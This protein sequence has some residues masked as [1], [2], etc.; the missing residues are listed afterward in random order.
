MVSAL[1]AMVRQSHWRVPFAA[2]LDVLRAAYE[3]IPE[4]ERHLGVID[5]AKTIEELKRGLE[6]ASATLDPD[7]REVARRNQ[8]RLEQ[9]LTAKPECDW[10]PNPFERG[11]GERL[12]LREG[13]MTVEYSLSETRGPDRSAAETPR[14]EPEDE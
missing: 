6:R 5:S 7:P 2:V 1:R 8:R 9:A 14:S 11:S 4:T 12:T 10:L 3:Q 13:S